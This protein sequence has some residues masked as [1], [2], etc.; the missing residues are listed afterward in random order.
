MEVPA[1]RGALRFAAGPSRYYDH[2]Y[3]RGL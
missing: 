2:A 1:V 3:L